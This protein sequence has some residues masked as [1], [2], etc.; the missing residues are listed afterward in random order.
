MK[1]WVRFRVKYEGTGESRSRGRKTK[2]LLISEL[3]LDGLHNQ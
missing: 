3:T 1:C 2:D